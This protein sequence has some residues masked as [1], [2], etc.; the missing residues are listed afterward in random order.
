MH[1][2]LVFTDIHRYN[3]TWYKTKAKRIVLI[4]P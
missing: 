2:N 4:N 1:S 3:T